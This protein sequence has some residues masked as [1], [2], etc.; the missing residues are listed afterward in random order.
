MLVNPLTGVPVGVLTT[1]TVYWLLVPVMIGLYYNMH[2][3]YQ[4]LLVD[5][6]RLCLPPD[7]S[8][9]FNHISYI[10]TSHA[11]NKGNA[12]CMQ[13]YPMMMVQLKILDTH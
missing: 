10:I 13:K 4:G 11:Y 8:I 5:L 12:M 3:H 2:A 9:I 6:D 1:V 7:T